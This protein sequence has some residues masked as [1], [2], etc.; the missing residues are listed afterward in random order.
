[1]KTVK[2]FSPILINFSKTRKLIKNGENNFTISTDFSGFPNFKK[3]DKSQTKSQTVTLLQSDVSD[4]TRLTF[5]DRSQTRL[6]Q[7]VCLICLT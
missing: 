3:S 6:R 2:L 1:M 5:F 4:Q 7:L